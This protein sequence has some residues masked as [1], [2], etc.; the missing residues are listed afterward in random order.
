MEQPSC[1]RENATSGQLWA[2]L[3]LPPLTTLWEGLPALV[4][5]A[6]LQTQLLQPLVWEQAVVVLLLPWLPVSPG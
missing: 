4:V 5:P 2:P 6:W 3:C 1:T